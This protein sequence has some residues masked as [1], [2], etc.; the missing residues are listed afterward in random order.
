MRLSSQESLLESESHHEGQPETEMR[1]ASQTTLVDP[2]MARPKIYYNDGPF[3][4]PSSSDEEGESL[5]ADEDR[6]EPPSS[7]GMA[8]LGGPASAGGRSPRRA[9]GITVRSAMFKLPI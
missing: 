3:D 2:I 9:T 1:Q 7:P 5:L 8:E 6:D 4:A